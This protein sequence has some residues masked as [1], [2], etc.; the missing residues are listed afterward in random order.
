MLVFSAFFSWNHFTFGQTAM[1]QAILSPLAIG[2]IVV[3]SLFPST[4][5]HEFRFFFLFPWYDRIAGICFEIA[6]FRHFL[7]QFVCN[8]LLCNGPIITYDFSS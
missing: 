8:T 4:S 3:G 6:L 1:K 7:A 5:Y 2:S